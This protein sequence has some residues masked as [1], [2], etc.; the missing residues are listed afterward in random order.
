M[1]K[2][3]SSKGELKENFSDQGNDFSLKGKSLKN[4]IIMFIFALLV[5]GV[6]IYF[7]TFS[8]GDGSVA[9]D[10]S[11]DNKILSDSIIIKET[12]GV[13]DI[14]KVDYVSLPGFLNDSITSDNI[15][16]YGVK[17]GDDIS[18]VVNN[19]KFGKPDLSASFNETGNVTNIE[20]REKF[21]LNKSGILFNT[22]DG[23]I[24][25]ITIKQPFS[26][27]LVGKS[28]MNH[29][30]R[31]IYDTYGLP[32]SQEQLPY[33]RIFHYPDRGMDL[34]VDKNKLNGVSFYI[35]ED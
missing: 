9:D 4:T 7:L 16:V 31:G 1:A 27:F 30:L 24:R 20:Y 2:R 18:S 10:T 3:D 32:D 33:F 12:E 19:P 29:S 21:G 28:N 14:I 13:Y 22:L 6:A 25:R 8:N 34:L 5:V 35:I 15:S 23:K 26:V 17:V 11:G